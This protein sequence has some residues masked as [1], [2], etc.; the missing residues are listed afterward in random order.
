MP[1][2]MGGVAAGAGAAAAPNGA[3]GEEERLPEGAELEG[4]CEDL[5]GALQASR[6]AVSGELRRS[7]G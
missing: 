7:Y 5:T 1:I 3:P 4:Y 2:A 6:W